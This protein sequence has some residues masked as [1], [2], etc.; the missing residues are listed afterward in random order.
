MLR[1]YYLTIATARLGAMV[2][3]ILVVYKSPLTVIY[4]MRFGFGIRVLK[5]K[6]TSGSATMLCAIFYNMKV[7]LLSL[8]NI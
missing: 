5:K 4:C 8:I 1:I 7:H 3:K 6:D 2:N